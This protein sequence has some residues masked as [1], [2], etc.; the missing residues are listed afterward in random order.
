MNPHL[1]GNVLKKY[2]HSKPLGESLLKIEILNQWDEICPPLIAKYARP[3]G[4]KGK[5]LSLAVNSSAWLNELSFFKNELIETL[6]QKAGKEVIK[7]I[8]F[9]LK[10]G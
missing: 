3:T 4:L 6:N 1:L 7:E 9:Y 10:E 2:I 8:R 5:K